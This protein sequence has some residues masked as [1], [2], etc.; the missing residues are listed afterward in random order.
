MYKSMLVWYYLFL[1]TTRGF[2]DEDFAYGVYSSRMR[3]LE[4]IIVVDTIRVYKPFKNLYKSS[5]L[6]VKNRWACCIDA[7]LYPA[8]VNFGSTLDWCHLFL[9]P[10]GYMHWGFY[11]LIYSTRAGVSV[12]SFKLQA[13][14][15]IM[16]GMNLPT[17]QFIEEPPRMRNSSCVV[18]CTWEAPSS[19]LTLSIEL[20]F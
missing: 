16:N 15:E 13:P 4:D 10:V 5:H 8:R 9:I 11:M 3:V 1:D 14:N 20:K 6:K 7:C 18:P 12:T 2:Y 17:I 19:I